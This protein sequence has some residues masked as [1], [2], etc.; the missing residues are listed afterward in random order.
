MAKKKNPIK[1]KADDVNKLAIPADNS[2]C[3]NIFT[4]VEANLQGKEVEIISFPHKEVVRES[5]RK[6]AK[7]HIKEFISVCYQGN[8]YRVLNRFTE[9]RPFDWAKLEAP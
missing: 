2:Y 8:T 5:E 1:A 4:R 6:R 9:I 3:R 7:P